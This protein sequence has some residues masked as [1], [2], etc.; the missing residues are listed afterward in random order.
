MVPLIGTEKISITN[1][2]LKK[3]LKIPKKPY[4]IKTNFKITAGLRLGLKLKLFDLEG[5]FILFFLYFAGK[6]DDDDL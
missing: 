5:K 6:I 4:K 3:V 2:S 1:L